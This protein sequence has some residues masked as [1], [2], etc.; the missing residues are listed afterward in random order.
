MVDISE[1]RRVADRF[2]IA[3]K[4]RLDFLK[5]SFLKMRKGQVAWLKVGEVHHQ[6]IYHKIFDEMPKPEIL[7]EALK[8]AKPIGK[9]IYIK[10]E[11]TNIKRDPKCCVSATFDQ[12]LAYFDK[13]R[14]LGKELIADDEI[15]NARMLYSRCIDCFKN[16]PKKEVSLLEENLQRKREEVLHILYLNQAFCLLKKEM[17]PQCIKAAEEALVLN[18]ESPKAFYRMAH[19][20]KGLRE[21]DQAKVNFESAIRLT[22]NDR[23]LRTEYESFVAFRKEAEQ[24]QWQKMSGF[25]NSPKMEMLKKKDEEE[26]ELRHKIKRQTF[27]TE[28]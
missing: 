17:Y 15:S 5:N 28:I 19:A 14:Q 11:V 4:Q 13:I 25:L 2:I 18:P 24:K 1:K 21:Y 3:D 16:I 23:S 22:P 20:Y 27:E 9:D 12:K 7:T 10:I 6:R 8:A 26:A